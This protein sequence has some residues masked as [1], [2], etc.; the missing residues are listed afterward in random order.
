MLGGKFRFSSWVDRGSIV[1][2]AITM[3]ISLI[4]TATSFNEYVDSKALQKEFARAVL[5]PQSLGA[6]KADELA[7]LKQ[8]V[9]S[10]TSTVA[11][12]QRPDSSSPQP[13][14]LVSLEGKME[15]LSARLSVL[16]SAISNS[17]E[18]ALAVPMLRKDHDALTKQ[19]ND[20]AIALKLD[21][22][23]LWGILMLILTVVGTSV[24][25]VGGWVFK[26]LITQPSKSSSE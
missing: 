1:A 3:V 4:F 19:V 24:L 21:Y 2:A 23:R 7:K 15:A 13:V 22:D 12:L 9:S 25:G 11:A 16:E 5:D 8:A 6:E 14:Q 18:R 10:L 20:A 17:P 26:N